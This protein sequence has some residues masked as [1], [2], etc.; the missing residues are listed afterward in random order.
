MMAM[1]VKKPK[2]ENFTLLDG[3]T[4]TYTVGRFIALFAFKDLW[5]MYV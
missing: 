5:S 3:Q 2:L 4:N 1:E